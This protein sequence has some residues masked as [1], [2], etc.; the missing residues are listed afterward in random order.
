MDKNALT[1]V[2]RT[3]DLYPDLI[4]LK[5]GGRGGEGRKLVYIF[6]PIVESQKLYVVFLMLKKALP[7]TS[8]C[9]ITKTDTNPLMFR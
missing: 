6:R 8:N 1:K 3:G 2:M 5:E 7:R 9:V 4:Q